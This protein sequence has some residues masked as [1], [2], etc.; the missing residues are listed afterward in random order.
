MI[1]VKN[2]YIVTFKNL[3]INKFCSKFYKS[4]EELEKFFEKLFLK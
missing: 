3:K 4:E 2:G 1:I